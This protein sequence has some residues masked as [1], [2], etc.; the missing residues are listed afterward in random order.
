MPLVLSRETA[1]HGV[2]V[3]VAVSAVVVAEYTGVLPESGPA[4]GVVSV[5]VFGA[6]FG[7]AHL[8]YAVRGADGTV[9]VTARWRY[10]G[11]L[12][13]LVAV[14][15]LVAVGGDRSLGPVSVRT[16][17]TVV[18]VLALATYLVTES[19]AGY[20]SFRDSPRR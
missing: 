14:G 3:F 19:V 15:T 12:A 13:V 20:R 10:V 8:S 11:L 5:L 17:G 4:A 1:V 18:G 2:F 16:V 9:P 6:I 7:G